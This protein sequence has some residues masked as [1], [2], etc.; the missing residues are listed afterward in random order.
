[1][2]RY[3][4]GDGKWE[5]WGFPSSMW[6]LSMEQRRETGKGGPQGEVQFSL[7]GFTWAAD[8]RAELM[9]IRQNL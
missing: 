2:G 8:A 7:C 3:E 6:A 4:E 9:N 5:L 1:M